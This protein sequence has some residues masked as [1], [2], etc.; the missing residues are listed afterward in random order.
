[1]AF[2]NFFYNLSI[3]KLKDYTV[4]RSGNN[5][6]LY[7]DVLSAIKNPRYAPKINSL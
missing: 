1:M 3:Q 4:T 5:S 2:Y 7:E 6:N